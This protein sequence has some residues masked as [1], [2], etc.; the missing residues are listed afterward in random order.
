MGMEDTF[1]VIRAGVIYELEPDPD[2]GFTISVPALPGC[3]SFGDTIEEAMNLILEAMEGWLAV[4]R[5]KGIPI[6]AQF[7]MKQAS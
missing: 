3:I 2:G 4:A 5:E 1:H 6:P 7:E